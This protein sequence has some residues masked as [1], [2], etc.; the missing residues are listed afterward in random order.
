MTLTKRRG[1]V[2]CICV[3]AVMTVGVCPAGIEEVLAPGVTVDRGAVNGV[4]IERNG[5][6]LMVYGDPQQRWKTADTVL[7]THSRR[8]V[9]WA[10]RSLVESGAQSIVPAGEAEQFAKVADFWT[11]FWGKRFHDYTQQSTRIMAAPL[12]VDRTVRQGDE[13]AWQDLTVRV[14]DT[15]GYTRAAV[16][17][18]VEVDGIKYGFVGDLIY[19]NG[20]LLD[21]YSLQDA[22]SEARIGGYHG[23]AGRI[24]DLLAS[25]RKVAA[26][27]PNILVPARGPVVREPAAAINRLIQRLQA[28]YENYLSISAGRW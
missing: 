22:V 20:H 9:A 24:G 28:A 11:S 26:Q 15:P 14:L 8:D 10:G 1:V 16:S 7:F 5:R 23:Y 17:Y 18:F 3:M 27:K 25:L 13:I 6:R 4:C 2:L 19:G 12:R 21:L